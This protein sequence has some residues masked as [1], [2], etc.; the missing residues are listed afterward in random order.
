MHSVA[1]WL[2]ID[3]AWLSK[4]RELKIYDHLLNEIFVSDNLEKVL[5]YKKIFMKMP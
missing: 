1:S 5:R 2:L 4:M 3:V